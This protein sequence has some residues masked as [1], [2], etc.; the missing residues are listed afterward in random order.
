MLNHTNPERTVLALALALLF[1]ASLLA[2]CTRRTQTPGA[3]DCAKVTDRRLARDYK[4]RVR[5]D[6]QF[7]EQR[8][9]I[10]VNVKDRVVTLEGYAMGA[11]AMTVLEKYAREVACV[12]KV[13]NR[14]TSASFSGSCGPGQKRCGDICIDQ[15]STCN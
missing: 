2:S 12:T 11:D 13:V 5:A 1:V 9:H 7:N 4:R 15:T 14:L 10:N 6:R 3:Q 8:R